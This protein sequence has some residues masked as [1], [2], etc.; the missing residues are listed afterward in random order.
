MLAELLGQAFDLC[1]EL[2]D[3]LV[4]GPVKGGDEFADLLHLQPEIC[5]EHDQIVQTGAHHPAVGGDDRIAAGPVQL[6]EYPCQIAGR[7]IDLHVLPSVNGAQSGIRIQE[8]S[9]RESAMYRAGIERPEPVGFCNRSPAVGDF[10]GNVT[11]LAQA[12][13]PAL[14]LGGYLARGEGR[15]AVFPEELG[16]YT[17]YGP[18]GR[19]CG[20]ALVDCQQM[21]GA[22]SARA[23]FQD[24]HTD[25]S[26]R[27]GFAQSRFIGQDPL[28]PEAHCGDFLGV[29]QGPC[30]LDPG[31]HAFLTGLL[32]GC[33]HIVG[34]PGGI[35]D[36]C[37]TDSLGPVPMADL[38]AIP[39][40]CHR[41][42][43]HGGGGQCGQGQL[44]FFTHTLRIIQ[45]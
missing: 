12:G 19:A 20:R 5:A 10:L 13:D 22:N 32:V 26:C 23:V 25:L 30:G 21:E 29:F 44:R 9:I 43:R 28:N 4:V 33:P 14:E 39:G 16:S 37:T 1:L 42:I 24:G 17:V 8:V 34:V 18:Y 35:L 27:T 6:G 36:H 11:V 31:C 38:I 15:V 7:V 41:H 45:A 3:S 2:D 40:A